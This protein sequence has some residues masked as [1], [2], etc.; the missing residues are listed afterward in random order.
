M[1]RSDWLNLFSIEH[2]HPL[3]PPEAVGTLRILVEESQGSG[4][5]PVLM[6]QAYT[7]WV[8]ASSAMLELARTYL[9]SNL[10]SPT[11]RLVLRQDENTCVVILRGFG[12]D[13]H[14]R[15]TICERLEAPPPVP[16]ADDNPY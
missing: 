14:A 8:E 9:P 1:A 16:P 13:H 6:P 4:W 5:F 10:S 11:E 12:R 2:A 15:I 7:D 3:D